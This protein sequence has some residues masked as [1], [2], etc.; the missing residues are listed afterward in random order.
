M[1][2]KP[3]WLVLKLLGI[4]VINYYAVHLALY[5][6]NMDKDYGVVAGI[7]ALVLLV[8][9]DFLIFYRWLKRVITRIIN[10]ELVK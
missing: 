9:T 5:C 3:Y 7:A 2:L 10:S 4:V 6:L 8:T 1:I